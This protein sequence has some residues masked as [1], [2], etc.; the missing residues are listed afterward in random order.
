LLMR[1]VTR[2]SSRLRSK[3]GLKKE[4][5]VFAAKTSKIPELKQKVR[6]ERKVWFR[7]N[8]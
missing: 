8:I 6:T 5:Y 2:K 7:A 1:A 3:P 4:A